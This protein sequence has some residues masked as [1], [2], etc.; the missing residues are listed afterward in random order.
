LKNSERSG[1]VGSTRDLTAVNVFDSVILPL[2]AVGDNVFTHRGQSVDFDHN[3]YDWLG[4]RPDCNRALLDW[5]VVCDH[6]G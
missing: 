1:L 2:S 6:L 4:R 5:S 3:F